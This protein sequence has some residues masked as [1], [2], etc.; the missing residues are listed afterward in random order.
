MK[1]SIDGMLGSRTQGSRMEGTDKS[2]ELWRHPSLMLPTVS[3]GKGADFR[4][5]VILDLVIVWIAQ[6]R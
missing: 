5:G 4:Q 1:K 2:T 3:E 6:I